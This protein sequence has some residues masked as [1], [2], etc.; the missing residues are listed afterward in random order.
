MC[1]R[2]QRDCPAALLAAADCVKLLMTELPLRLLVPTTSM[3]RVFLFLLPS[4]QPTKN[5]DDD[6][7]EP[8][9]ITDG[10]SYTKCTH[11]PIPPATHPN[12]TADSD[13]GTNATEREIRYICSIN[14]DD[15]NG[16][17]NH[18]HNKSTHTKKIN[19]GGTAL[20]FT[21]CT[22]SVLNKKS[23]LFRICNKK[24]LLFEI[25]TTKND[26]TPRL[27]QTTYRGGTQCDPISIFDI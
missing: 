17:R 14:D 7:T 9:E 13:Y 18:N 23:V 19:R 1:L 16:E 22:V 4:F 12:H 15:K 5:T 21:C 26:S 10:H 25:C 11:T 24:R 2:Y 20:P 3:M 27:Y 6:W 8:I